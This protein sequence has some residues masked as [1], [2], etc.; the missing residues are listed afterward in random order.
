MLLHVYELCP[1]AM[2]VHHLWSGS[3]VFTAL[4]VIS[5]STT[6]G[7]VTPIDSVVT[8]PTDV[9]Q[10]SKPLK[11]LW[12]AVKACS[13]MR[14]T[15]TMA[16]RSAEWMD[17]YARATVQ[18]VSRELFSRFGLSSRLYGK[19][20]VQSTV[21]TLQQWKVHGRK[22]AWSKEPVKNCDPWSQLCLQSLWEW[23]PLES[24]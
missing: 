5:W 12:S 3:A 19:S 1:R 10:W 6:Q 20:L 7:V 2:K 21:K 22:S 4:G 18:L 9:V 16:S 23:P 24:S 13:E 11:R 14:S 8:S 17:T 15:L